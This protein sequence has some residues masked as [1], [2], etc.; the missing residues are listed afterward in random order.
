MPGI[1][2]EKEKNLV[3][4]DIEELISVRLASMLQNNPSRMDYYE[5]DMA[6]INGYNAEQDRATIEKTFMD[7]MNLT[8]SMTQE[9]K[10]Y[11]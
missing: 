8:N 3:N 4:R 10:R 6:I 2:Q 1:C 7:L 5:R 9:E 11:V